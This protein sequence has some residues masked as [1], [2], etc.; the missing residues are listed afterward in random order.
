MEEATSKGGLSRFSVSLSSKQTDRK[1]LINNDQGSNQF[2][3]YITL[4]FNNIFHCNRDFVLY[5]YFFFINILLCYVIFKY[6]HKM[7][8]CRQVATLTTAHLHQLTYQQS[9]K[10]PEATMDRFQKNG[11]RDSGCLKGV[12]VELISLGI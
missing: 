9:V 3:N 5:R 1:L 2:K 6:P 12:I 10:F 11:N 8:I 4:L 7:E